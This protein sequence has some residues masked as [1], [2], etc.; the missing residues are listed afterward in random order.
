MS[1]RITDPITSFSIP[2]ASVVP[3]AAYSPAT[4][5]IVDLRG[6]KSKG[7]LVK[8][9]GTNSITYQVNGSYDDG[10]T[11]D[12][13]IQSDT[14]VAASTSSNY[15]DTDYA[16]FWQIR[17]KASTAS[18]SGTS[19]SGAAPAT[20]ISSGTLT[21]NLNGDGARSLYF[22]P[23][24]SSSEGPADGSI[25]TNINAQTLTSGATIAAAIQSLVNNMLPNQT[26]NAT[27]YAGFTAT[28]TGSQYVLTSGTAGSGSSVVITPGIENDLSAAL[29]LGLSGGGTEVA[30]TSAASSA[31][32][33]LVALGV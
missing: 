17:T 8:N 15:N 18:T 31:V 23:A 20:T 26:A 16:T 5:V 12:V 4:D 28:Y 14:V 7:L 25:P 11:Y 2:P 21:I 13:V 27:A 6:M 22:P 33:K 32:I 30:G 24:L 19:T 3:L 10:K 9:T 29:K 1:T